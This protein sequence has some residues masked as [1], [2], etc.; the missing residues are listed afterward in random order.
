MKRTDGSHSNSHVST[1]SLLWMIPIFLLLTVTGNCS[2]DVV[3]FNGTTLDGWAHTGDGYF[4]VDEKDKALV[5][6]GGM[7]MLFYYDRQFEDFELNL[8]FS[9]NKEDA[10][11]GVFVRFPNLPKIG[12]KPH[13]GPWGAVNE[14]YEFQIQGQHTGDLYSFQESS[15]V[16]LKEPG[17]YN[18][19][20][21][22]A[23]GQHYKVW[24]NDKLV[25]DY[26]GERSTKGYVG[27][28]NHDP[29][30]IVRFKNIVVTPK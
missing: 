4:N 12:G 2:D 30:S 23:T 14:G 27:V 29:N 22:E 5:S 24:V 11:S 17:Q 3:L 28:Q 9:V 25:G 16:P 10:N 26:T 7:G 15:E 21:I 1:K 18:H 13:P 19:M 20:K 6:H 8:D